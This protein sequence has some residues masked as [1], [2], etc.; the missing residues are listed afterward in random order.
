MKQIRLKLA[1]LL[2]DGGEARIE[3]L[4]KV[5]VEAYSNAEHQEL[6]MMRLPAILNTVFGTHHPN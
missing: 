5:V 3:Q 4:N 2:D 1:A 6:I